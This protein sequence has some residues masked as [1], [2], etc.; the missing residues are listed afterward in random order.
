LKIG[1]LNEKQFRVLKL[2]AKGLTQLEAAKELKTSRANISMIESRARKKIWKAK[3]TL[4]AYEA[5]Q[6]FQTIEIEKG[7]R[8]P[9]IPLRVLHTGDRLHIH[10]QSDLVEIVRLV[11]AVKPSCISDGVTTRAITFKINPRGKL[12]VS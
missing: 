3:E 6:T 5:L 9:Q 7:I 10:V 4:R 12:S 8:L 2:R 11:R 1:L